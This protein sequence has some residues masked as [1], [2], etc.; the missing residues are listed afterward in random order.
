[1]ST[2][3]E[4]V[5][6]FVGSTFEDL[7]DYRQAVQNELMRLE[8]IVKGMELFGS[9]P[10]TPLDECLKKVNE[11]K[12]YIGIFAMRYGSIEEDSQKSFTQ[13]EFEEAQRLSLPS[14]IYIIDENNQPVLPKYVDT[15]EK[16]K[17]L[18]DLKE[19]LKKNFVVSYF[20]SPD[21]LARKIANDLPHVIEEITEQKIDITPDNESDFDIFIRFMKRPQ[22]YYGREISLRIKL[23]SSYYALSHSYA[24]AFGLKEGSAIF[25]QAELIQKNDEI[26]NS[27]V[28]VLMDGEVADWYE[29]NNPTGIFD[30]K[31]RLLY[32][33]VRTKTNASNGIFI[34][35]EVVTQLLV[36][37]IPKEVKSNN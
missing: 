30:F 35:S 32:A 37:G 23:S 29:D 4:H 20:T 36:L 26:K 24:E 27:T 10:N 12:I 21:D 5:A 11:S 14:L 8:A 22:K 16:A 7:K 1:M 9:T 3:K 2:K 31:I 34:D 17:K 19:Y 25:T 13:L 15:G 6:V 33:T 18:S 28:S